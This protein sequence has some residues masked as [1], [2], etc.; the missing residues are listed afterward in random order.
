MKAEYFDEVIYLVNI[1][2]PKFKLF[3]NLHTGKVKSKKDEYP[4]TEPES[5][6]L[7]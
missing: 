3:P 2:L 6:E 5:D 4:T 1:P 7:S